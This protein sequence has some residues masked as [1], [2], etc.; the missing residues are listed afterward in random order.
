M[1]LKILISLVE[2]VFFFLFSN[3]HTCPAFWES[4]QYKVII[5]LK[6]MFFFSV[7]LFSGNNIRRTWRPS[8]FRWVA[9]T[10]RLRIRSHRLVI[11]SIKF[12]RNIR[13]RIC[14]SCPWAIPAAS[15]TSHQELCR[16]SC[17]TCRSW[18]WR[19]GR[20]V[21]ELKLEELRSLARRYIYVYTY[22]YTII[23]FSNNFEKDIW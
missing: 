6:K 23:I 14:N 4:V 5:L 1:Q 12:T 11:I 7:F 20:L 16:R 8:L 17:A 18:L 13:C 10:C 21:W 3:T 2:S 15:I 19:W 9:F 22:I